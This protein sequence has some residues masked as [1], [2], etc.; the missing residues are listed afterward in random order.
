MKRRRWP[1]LVLA[2]ALMLTIPAVTLGRAVQR[3]VSPHPHE[4]IVAQCSPDGTNINIAID[5][6]NLGDDTTRFSIFV[7]IV[8]EPLGQVVRSATL[9]TDGVR[10]ERSARVTALVPSNQQNVDCVIVAVG[11]ELPFGID[12]GPV[13]PIRINVP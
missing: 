7:E 1:W 6:T 4:L 11:G 5:I 9:T 12:I 2:V 8:G 13:E 3:F 10:P